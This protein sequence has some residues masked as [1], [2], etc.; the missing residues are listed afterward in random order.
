MKVP[1]RPLFVAPRIYRR[2]RLIDAARILPVL[3]AVLLIVPLL[4]PSTPENPRSTAF[5]GLYLFGVWALLIFG[6]WALAPGL[7]ESDPQVRANDG[8]D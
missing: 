2:R 4:H 7:K 3:G 8:D 5:D 6:A 1:G